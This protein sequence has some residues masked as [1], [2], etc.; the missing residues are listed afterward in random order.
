MAVTL[1]AT[2]GRLAS[3]S[4]LSRVAKFA[5]SRDV[6]AALQTEMIEHQ[7]QARI[8][9]GHLVGEMHVLVMEQH[10][11]RDAELLHL[12]PHP[13]EAAVEQRLAQH[14]ACGR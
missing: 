11:R 6:L 2:L 7:P 13:V 3:A 4:T 14:L 5:A 12:A 9:L 8:A 1:A 10:H